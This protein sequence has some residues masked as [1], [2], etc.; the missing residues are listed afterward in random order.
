MQDDVS[1]ACVATPSGGP[2]DAV[3]PSL[4]T[5]IERL[6][7]S[8]ERLQADSVALQSSNA[9]LRSVND[10]L[11]LRSAALEHAADGL[12]LIDL[13][14]P[15]RPIV[16]ASRSF[17]AL[18]GYPPDE[19]L[20]R[21]LSL[22]HGQKTDPAVARRVSEAIAAREPVT[23][24]AL[25]YRRD[26]RSF[27][28]EIRLTPVAIGGTVRHYAALFA[29]ISPRKRVE[30]DTRRRA[31]FDTLTGLPKR[32]LLLDR[33]T[34]QLGSASRN[35]AVGYV[36]LIDLD[37]FK[38]INNTQGRAV[39][40]QL[41]VDAAARLLDC[42]RETDTVAHAG[43]DEFVILLADVSG[44]D[45]V[46]KVANSVLAELRRPFS[47]G[48]E[49]PRLSASIGIATYPEDALDAEILIQHA[50]TAMRRTKAT[51]RD[52]FT[53]FQPAMNAEAVSRAETKQAIFGG[54]EQRQFELYYQPIVAIDSGR[55]VAAEALLRWNH[56]QDGLVGP[57]RFVRLAE[58]TGQI[59][60]L[61]NWV[62]E[63][64]V[65]QLHDWAG[66]LD[67]DFR[68]AINVSARQL[69]DAGLTALLDRLPH[70]V[71]A[72][73][74]FEITESTFLDKRRAVKICLE[75]MRRKGG[76]ISLDDFGT[77][78]SSLRFL[79]DFPIDTLKIDRDFIK[80]DLQDVR[81][82]ALVESIFA[83]ARGIGAEVVAEGIETDA[84][85]DFVRDHGCQRA[86]GYLFAEPL[87]AAS[88]AALYQAHRDRAL[89]SCRAL[90][91]H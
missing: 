57:S 12:V 62:L 15:D 14:Q 51:R 34:R 26:S 42:V 23:V 20:G 82:A 74:E 53:F 70:A 16:Y 4:R 84:Q 29:D 47:L 79:L 89:P 11:A 87:D 83:I 77:G 44:L 50:D 48:T 21:P 59:I 19:T 32:T 88:F 1:G 78:Y 28:S 56:P 86:Q 7:S 61:G 8:N 24:E 38:E 85:L 18:S 73:L 75:L 46:I 58:D 6:E 67:E 60:P 27:W 49:T 80:A 31:T 3:P 65:R 36:L 54:L 10:E 81:N 25:N 40:D 52:Q 66:L 35:E 64:A 76:H 55:V 2:T 33:L 17:Q 90:E 45:A 69:H 63:R 71:V 72:Q 39:G 5:L 13:E 22:L 41:L 68:L 43:G 30:R 9:A 37:G 91:L